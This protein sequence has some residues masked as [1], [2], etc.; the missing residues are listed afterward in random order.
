W[1]HCELS[2]KPQKT[3]KDLLEKVNPSPI[4]RRQDKRYYAYIYGYYRRSKGYGGYGI[5]FRDKFK[6]PV[7]GYYGVSKGRSYLYYLL[8]GMKRGLEIAAGRDFDRVR[9]SIN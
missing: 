6:K 1:V 5:F 7:C 4:S 9:F 2:N 3:M 8:L